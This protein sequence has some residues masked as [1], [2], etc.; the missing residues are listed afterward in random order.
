MY[1]VDDIAKSALENFSRLKISMD[2]C[3]GDDGAALTVNATPIWEGLMTLKNKG[4][5]IRWITD[6]TKENLK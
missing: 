2:T 3:V 6:I 1:D 4:V 5:K